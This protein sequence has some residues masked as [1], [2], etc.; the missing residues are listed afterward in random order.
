MGWAEGI[1]QR[2]AETRTADLK[3]KAN[4]ED[5]ESKSQR[6]K[7]LV[8]RLGRDAASLL[9]EQG[10]KPVRVILASASPSF[11]TMV[12]DGEMGWIVV[13][14]GAQ[15]SDRVY[16]LTDG[17]LRGFYTQ[18]ES[19]RLRTVDLAHELANSFQ[20]PGGAQFGPYVMMSDGTLRR[21]SS[22]SNGHTVA[23]S[24]FQTFFEGWL[25]RTLADHDPSIG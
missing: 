1:E 18:S 25:I 15:V 10:I 20:A 7:D 23:V 6:I 9:K 3:Q 22:D 13:S 24:N 11:T 17:R 14:G 12:V 16:L 21:T 5:P 4:F 19:T 2:V 8:T